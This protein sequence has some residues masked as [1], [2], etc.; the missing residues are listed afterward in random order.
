ME[1]L[2]V[3]LKL[4]TNFELQKCIQELGDCEDFGDKTIE[5]SDYVRLSKKYS[6]IIVLMA[7]HFLGVKGIKHYA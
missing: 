3:Y 6:P 4:T 5:Y 1:T 2:L 7:E